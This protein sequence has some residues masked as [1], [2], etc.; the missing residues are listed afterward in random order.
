[1]QMFDGSLAVPQFTDKW[2]V[3]MTPDWK[4]AFRHTAAEADRLGLEMSMAASGGWTETAGPWV[5]PEQAMKKLVWSETRVQ[6]PQKFSRALPNPPTLNGRFQDT[7]APPS[8]E[9]P[10]IRG[11]P[12]AKETPIVPPTPNAPLLRRHCCRSRNR[13]GSPHPRQAHRRDRVIHLHAEYSC[14]GTVTVLF[15]A[16]RGQALCHGRESHCVSY[17]RSA[18]VRR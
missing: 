16:A 3:W 9:V 14:V 18:A 1:M 5:K 10:E 4:D 15:E 13:I 12:G 7:P 17:F 11:L 2:L 6:G 8:L